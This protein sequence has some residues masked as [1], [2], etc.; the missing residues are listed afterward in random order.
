MF[1]PPVEKAII[2]FFRRVA[3]GFSGNEKVRTR[4]NG[5]ARGTVFFLLVE[6][7]L[8]AHFRLVKGIGGRGEARWG[9]GQRGVGGVPDRNELTST[10]LISALMWSCPSGPSSPREGPGPKT[11]TVLGPGPI[12]FQNGP[13]GLDRFGANRSE[14]SGPF[15]RKSVREVWTDLVQIGPRC[16]DL[17]SD[18]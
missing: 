5:D 15:W 12:R 16:L 14:V 4:R 13:R 17:P 3:K 11:K 7:A 10:R 9:R 6:M 18:C 8:I 1:L 2:L